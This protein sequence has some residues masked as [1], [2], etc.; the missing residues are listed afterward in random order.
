MRI[1]AQSPQRIEWEE[2]VMRSLV[3][4]GVC[5]SDAQS[6]VET[7][8]GEALLSALFEADTVPSSAAQRF[9]E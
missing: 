8:K 9:I 6:M 1:T 4:S 7:G 3:A 5:R 2:A